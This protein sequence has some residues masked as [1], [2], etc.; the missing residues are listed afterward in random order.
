M[1][2]ITGHG[3]ESSIDRGVATT[4]RPRASCDSPGR[5]LRRYSAAG[6]L[7]ALAATSCAPAEPS[8]SPPT[9]PPATA[10]AAG[11]ADFDR[12]DASADYPLP[13]CVVSG[14]AL[15]AMGKPMAIVY[16]GTEVQFCCP[17]CLDEFKKEPAKF[18]AQV[19]AAKR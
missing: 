15:T 4:R 13:T 9:V 14:E 3:P 11:R 19:R 8:A 10:P 6:L 2:R 17:A 18:V 1:N 5:Q 16:Q 12:I 7:A